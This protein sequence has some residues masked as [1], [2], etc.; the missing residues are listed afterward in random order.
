MSSV[1]NA[2][3]L[4]ELDQNPPQGKKRSGSEG[5]D[6]L[7]KF[8]EDHADKKLRSMAMPVAT[9]SIEPTRLDILHNEVILLKVS[10]FSLNF[11]SILS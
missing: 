2:K 10:I 11:F 3:Q 1:I 9:Q 7:V 6:A 4:S 8:P 5:D